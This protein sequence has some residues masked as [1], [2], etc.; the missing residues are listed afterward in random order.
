M[1]EELYDS[2][3]DSEDSEGIIDPNNG[4]MYNYNALSR[5]QKIEVLTQLSRRTR[6]LANLHKQYLNARTEEEKNVIAIETEY[7][8]IELVFLLNEFGIAIPN[9]EFLNHAEDS[10]SSE[11]V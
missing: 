9:E 3:Y 1:S 6:N 2:E 11:S 4:I 5:E 7:E 10:E 8:S